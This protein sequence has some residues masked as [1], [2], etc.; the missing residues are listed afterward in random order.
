[1]FSPEGWDGT[2]YL[3]SHFARLPVDGLSPL[4]VLRFARALLELT[5]TTV[6][7]YFILLASFS[8]LK[9]RE[10]GTIWQCYA[11]KFP[12]NSGQPQQIPGT[13][14]SPIF[15][16]H[17]RKGSKISLRR[18][19]SRSSKPPTIA[20]PRPRRAVEQQAV[21]EGILSYRGG[22]SV[23]YE[24]EH[25]R[26]GMIPIGKPSVVLVLDQ[27]Q[28][29]PAIPPAAHSLYPE[30]MRAT[31]ASRCPPTRADLSLAMPP[32]AHDPSPVGNWPQLN[33]PTRRLGHRHKAAEEAAA[34]YPPV[35]PTSR[36]RPSG[37]RR[38]SLTFARPSIPIP[39]P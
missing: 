20:A 1:M 31:I 10:D 27:G 25:Y 28:A 33:P 23:E 30:H 38:P 16:H 36:S 18:F 4:Y 35:S 24:I 26:P 8:L 15:H 11:R 39:N 6:L 7:C 22:L 5:L 29:A 3:Q 37:P 14:L 32:P 13:P 34:S 17:Q 21:H 12:W 9:S 19:L 2:V